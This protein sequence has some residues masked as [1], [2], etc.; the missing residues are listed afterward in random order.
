MEEFT[1]PSVEAIR[2]RLQRVRSIAV[3]GLSPDESRP[4]HRV[5]RA[6]QAAGFRIIPVR[7]GGGTVLGES[8]RASLDEIDGPVDLVDVFRA[9]EHVSGIIDDVLRL[10]LPA[11]WLQDGVIDHAAALR[12]EA[13]GVFVVMDRCLYRDGLPL[14]DLSALKDAKT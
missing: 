3:I 5:A 7:P 13:A 1:N 8:V 11:V 10:G 14:V 6:M 12:A 9:S 2:A 4:S